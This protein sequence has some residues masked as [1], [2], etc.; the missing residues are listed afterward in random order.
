M[1]EAMVTINVETVRD[2][3]AR[4]AAIA[5]RVVFTCLRELQDDELEEP[6]CTLQDGFFH[7]GL[8]EFHATQDERRAIYSQWL[9]AKGFQDILRGMRESLEEAYFVCELLALSCKPLPMAFPEIIDRTRLK[10]SKAKLPQL[11]KLVNERLVEPLEFSEA[12]TS[13][14]SARN[15]LEHRRGVVG[16]T[17]VNDDGKFILQIPTVAMWVK[18]LSG[19]EELLTP[20]NA[21]LEAGE[22]VMMRLATE[23][24]ELVLGETLT[25]TRDEFLHVALAGMQFGQ[26]LVQRLPEPAGGAADDAPAPEV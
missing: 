7:V 16:Q 8:G 26:T 1:N 17:D 19:E 12:L 10:A 13:L 22:G 21:F 18:R 23:R 24:R 6:T 14:Q 3:S 25:I 5:E 20:A 15:C 9:V 11:L 4:A 2:R